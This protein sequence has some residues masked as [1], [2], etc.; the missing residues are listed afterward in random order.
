M[1]W[2]YLSPNK[3]VE[4]HRTRSPSLAFIEVGDIITT[5]LRLLVSL[6][7]SSVITCLLTLHRNGMHL[8]ADTLFIMLR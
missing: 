7:R 1:E 6:A 8:T 3:S 5:E 2:D 4:V